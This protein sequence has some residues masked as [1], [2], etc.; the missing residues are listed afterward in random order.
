VWA[1]QQQTFVVVGAGI[2]GAKAAET[3]REQ[4][5]AGRS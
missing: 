3:L 2:A 5:F 1:G 4:G